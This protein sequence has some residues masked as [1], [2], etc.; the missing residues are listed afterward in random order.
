MVGCNFGTQ[1]YNLFFTDK[2]DVD[3]VRNPFKLTGAEKTE[4]SQMLAKSRMKVPT[5]FSGDVK[6]LVRQSGHFRAV[7]FIHFLKY[8]LGTTFLH[9]FPKRIRNALSSFAAICNIAGQKEIDAEDIAELTKHIKCWRDT[10]IE[11][12]NNEEIQPWFFNLYQHMITHLV[13]TLLNLGPM[14][15]FGAFSMETTI[16]QVKKGTL[17]NKDPGTNGGNFLI[18]MAAL[19]ELERKGLFDDMEDDSRKKVISI[20]DDDDSP[21]LWPPMKKTNLSNEEVNALVEF[22]LI[23]TNRTNWVERNI[24]LDAASRLWKKGYPV[25]SSRLNHVEGQ[26]TSFWVRLL[27]PVGKKGN[28]FSYFGEVQYYFKYT[29]PDDDDRLLAFVKVFEHKKIKTEVWPYKVLSAPSKIKV[30]DVENIVS[31]CGRS[32]ARM[33]REYIYW[34]KE[35]KT[36]APLGDYSKI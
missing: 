36:Y 25:V 30:V 15:V 27:I 34:V 19:Y 13:F 24:K 4:I 6:D 20:N 5:S 18:E 33:S 28:L 32:D 7:D 17:S 2:F 12:I 29:L 31:I 21:E 9:F 3:G 11:L 35:K 22:V 1:F 23:C 10:I 16:G 8:N 14:Y 26:R